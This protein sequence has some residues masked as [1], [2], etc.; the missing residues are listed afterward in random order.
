MPFPKQTIDRGDN[1]GARKHRRGAA[2]VEFAVL[3]PILLLLFLGIVE[4]GQFVNIGHSV[5]NASREGA[6]IAARQSTTNVAQ[7]TTA[8]S[9]YLTDAYPNLPSSAVQVAVVNAGSPITAGGLATVATGSP[10]SVQVVLQFDPVRWINGF[11]F[12]NGRTVTK[13][14]VTRRE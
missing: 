9:D 12:L 8:V 3:S 10:I 5:S 11:T 14:T 6:R 7:V 4:V 1:R 13:A 2:C